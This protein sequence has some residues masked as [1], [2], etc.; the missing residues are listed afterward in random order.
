MNRKRV[1]DKRI[2]QY[3]G[4]GDGCT[5]A[6]YS[7][8]FEKINFVL[9]TNIC[10][11]YAADEADDMSLFVPSCILEETTKY[12]EDDDNNNRRL[13]H[14]SI[15]TSTQKKSMHDYHFLQ[16]FDS[17]AFAQLLR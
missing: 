10:G 15:S 11:F 3:G 17:D 4:V 1:E 13:Y 6:K 2:Q 7:I 14:T 8:V 16:S 5:T 12:D 9:T